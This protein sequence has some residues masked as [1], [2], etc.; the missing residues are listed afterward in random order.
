MLKKKNISSTSERFEKT[1]V[2]VK[3]NVVEAIWYKYSDELYQCIICADE[4]SDLFD[5]PLIDR[6][7][8]N[9]HNM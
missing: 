7:V 3:F 6:N 2:N 1:E 5:A 4:N 8:K 9:V